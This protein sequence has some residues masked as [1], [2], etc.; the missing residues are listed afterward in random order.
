MA[1]AVDLPLEL[2]PELETHQPPAARPPP[3]QHAHEPL[4]SARSREPIR[5]APRSE[6]AQLR[7]ERAAG[8]ERGLHRAGERLRLRARGALHER[9][10]RKVRAR[11]AS[12]GSKLACVTRGSRAFL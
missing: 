3:L 2:L 7:E 5:G 10:R 9:E 12:S 8:V 1:D 11:G 6:G 4:D